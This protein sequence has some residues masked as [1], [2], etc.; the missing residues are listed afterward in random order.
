MSKKRSNRFDPDYRKQGWNKSRFAPKHGGLNITQLSSLIVL[1][2]S[3]LLYVIPET[4]RGLLT[5]QG[6]IIFGVGVFVAQAIVARLIRR[7]EWRRLQNQNKPINVTFDDIGE[8][9][10]ASSPNK[11]PNESDKFEHEVAGLINTLTSYKAVR[12]GGSG[13][14]GVDVKVY[15]GSELIWVVQCKQYNPNTALPPNHVRELFA[16]REQFKAKKAYLF[17]TARFTPDTRQEAERLQINLVDGADYERMRQQARA[18]QRQ[19]DERM[20]G[21]NL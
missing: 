13:D 6:F 4:R 17:T 20:T 19:R 8:P 18:Q 11:P 7:I 2:P 21:T 9:P 5:L 16:V 15:D 14:G 10:T 12:V 3:A 1:I